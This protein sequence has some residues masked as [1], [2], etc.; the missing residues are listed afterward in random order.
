M[1][2]TTS[3]AIGEHQFDVPLVGLMRLVVEQQR[4]GELKEG[5]DAMMLALST[6]KPPSSSTHLTLPA[7]IGASLQGGI[8]VGPMFDL[9]AGEV[10]HQIAGDYLAQDDWEDAMNAAKEYRA[11][12]FNDWQLPTQQQAMSAYLCAAK[13]FQHGFH[14]TSTPYG[15][16]HAWVVDFKLGYVTT[17]SRTNEWRVRPF[18]RFIP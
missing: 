11:G 4:Q 12:H 5:I 16:S 9:E 2:K 6:L 1:Q 13:H 10:I 8:Y 15:S 17:L 18:R 14:W 7:K 3:V